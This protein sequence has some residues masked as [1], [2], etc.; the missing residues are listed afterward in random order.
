[1][2]RKKDKIVHENPVKEAM[3]AALPTTEEQLLDLYL[4]LSIKLRDNYFANTDRAAEIAGVTQRTIQLWIECRLIG[5]VFIGGKYRVSLSSL[6][7]YIR[8][9]ANNQLKM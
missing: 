4:D 6:R 3:L 1:M 8:K 7:E 2:S 5:A 9:R